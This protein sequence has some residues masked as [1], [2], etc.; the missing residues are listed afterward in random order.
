[1]KTVIG[2]GKAGCG[3]AEEFSKYPQYDVYKIKVAS[4]KSQS[5]NVFGMS[6]RK[7]PESY[8]KNCPSLKTF[9]KKVDGDVLFIVD[10]SE[11]VSASSLRI[12]EQ[13]KHC[14][15]T[16]LYIRPEL[17]FLSDS[18]RLNERTVRG[19]LQEYA[20]SAVLER[21]Y[22]V[23]VSLV[24]AT[25]AEVPIKFYHEKVHEAIAATLHMI[26]VFR[27]SEAVLGAQGNP[28]DVARIS[29]FGF[30]NADS[31]KEN[32]FFALDFPREKSYYYGINEKK[33]QTDGSL[34]KKVNE[35]VSAD[36]HDN[37]RTS[38]AIYETRYENDYIY[39]TAHSSMVQL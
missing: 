9:F 27:H 25:L 37:L 7:T 38:Y 1:M 11:S 36:A 33:L 13:L 26:T 39:L 30:V 15:T 24:A 28:L 2:L 20:R 4:R 31:G 6:K 14:D 10:G 16:V 19:V 35:Q 21:I 32:L 8:E 22:L 17:Q 18:E 3:V 5:S 12:L 23:D 34:M 29:T